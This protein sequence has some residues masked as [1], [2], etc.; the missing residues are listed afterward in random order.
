MYVLPKHRDTNYGKPPLEAFA[1]NLMDIRAVPATPG[2]T[3]IWTHALVHWGSRTSELA[4]APRLSMSVEFQRA[5]VRPFSGF[6]I[7][8]NHHLTLEQ[9]LGLIGLGITKYEHM[10]PLGDG[11]SEMARRW[12][13][14]IPEVFGQRRPVAPEPTPPGATAAR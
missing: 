4:A 13:D 11:L 5:D 1:G 10:H 9:K 8:P 3:L 12:R 14:R 6:C 7:G 2:D